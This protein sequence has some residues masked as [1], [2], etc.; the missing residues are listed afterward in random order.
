MTRGEKLKKL[1]ED[2]GLTQLQLVEKLGVNKNTIS[3]AEQN[4][5]I[6]NTTMELFANFFN[7]SLDYLKSDDIENATN[8]AIEINKLLGFSD[9]TISNLKNAKYKKDLNLFFESLD[10]DYISWYLNLLNYSFKYYN[11]IA[12]VLIGRY[13]N[14]SQMETDLEALLP[15]LNYSPYNGL[16]DT[17]SNFLED[18]KKTSIKKA[19]KKN[20]NILFNA[21][22]NIL[23]FID[24][25]KYRLSS[26]IGFALDTC[27][28]TTNIDVIL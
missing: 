17:I 27:F 14:V 4:G 26:T 7:V 18:V 10:F 28:D 6:S 16:Y 2:M 9:K 23:L 1:R 3:K 22:N 21:L 5:N 24:S 20:H 12:N 8:E 19:E 25:H 11:F 13:Q 15:V